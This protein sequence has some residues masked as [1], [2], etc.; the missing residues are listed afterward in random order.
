M[1]GLPYHSVSQ[2]RQ[3]AT[4]L[5]HSQKRSLG[6]SLVDFLHKRQRQG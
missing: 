1:G 2:Q 3:V 5:A 4:H 6:K